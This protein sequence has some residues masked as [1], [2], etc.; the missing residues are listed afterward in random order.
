MA[1]VEPVSNAAT[2]PP[3]REPLAVTVV[4]P[5]ISG[6]GGMERMLYELIS[7]L[8]AAG[9]EVTVVAWSCDL[10]ASV[11]VRFKRVRGPTRPFVIAYPWFALA[12]SAILSRHRR[13]VVHATGAIVVNRVDVIAVHLCHAAIA[14]QRGL[15]RASRE[16][17]VYRLHA[18][19][20]ARMSLIAE[21]WSYRPAR[22][23]AFVAVSDGIAGELT[24]LYPRIAE[25]V[26]TIPNGVDLTEFHP[27]ETAAATDR[28]GAGLPVGVPVALF[29]GSEWKR[30][31]LAIAIEALAGAE[32]WHLAV[33]GEGDERAFGERAAQH[34]V[35]ERVHFL[36]RRTN[37]AELYRQCDAFL[38]PSA[39]E[40]AS[41]AMYEAA[42]SGLPLLIPRLSGASDLLE[43]GVS[44]YFI[45]RDAANVRA[46]LREL[47]DERLRDRLGAA[48]RAAAEPYSWA[49][50]MARHLQ[51]YREL[52][53][54]E[55]GSPPH[56]AVGTRS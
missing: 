25:Q 42:A 11:P 41:L 27:R 21:R 54:G 30:K 10:P 47:T 1:R 7:R 53:A 20:A 39:Y 52:G 14:R 50:T 43:D 2:S 6:V 51:L 35:K 12:A 19:V 36:G 5:H 44:G 18:R 4:A 23:R 38:F 48:A 3:E 49:E 33:V 26:V 31:G 17:P 8:V 32:P 40:A 29:V 22:A 34:G 37:V 9:V 46:R 56:D 15:V 24:E 45:E 13:G 28:A 55:R 16:H